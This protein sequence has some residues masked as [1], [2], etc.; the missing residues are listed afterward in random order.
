MAL[1]ACSTGTDAT[2]AGDGTGTSNLSIGY[3]PVV[4]S[5]PVVQ[6]DNGG[7]FGDEGLDVELGQTTGGAQAIPALMAGEYDIVFSNYVS[8]ILA[9]QQGLP[10]QVIAANNVG[11]AD[12]GIVVPADS[13]VQSV[14][15]LEG[16]KVAVS[17]LK[18]IGVL[19]I[20]AIMMDAGADPN[21]VQFVELPYPDMQGALER[22]DIDAMWLVEPFMANAIDSGHR[23]LTSLFTGTMENAPVSGW[24][25]TAEF[26]QQNP[27][28]IAAF[29][30]A[31][32]TA[33]DE[34]NDDRAAVTALVPTY[35]NM[36]EEQVS[37]I[38][39]PV[40]GAEIDQ[41][42]IASIADIMLKIGFI[43]DPFD[44]SSSFIY[45]GGQS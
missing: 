32:T 34:L 28:T 19:G 30:R 25:T 2:P 10:I 44:V 11:A 6:A 12:H 27:D 4:D 37:D 16:T 13:S 3:F 33:A 20:S 23:L 17:H 45:A 14:A 42:G 15:D 36:T 43:T 18:N 21:E 7:A 31:I 39:L 40:W 5:A 26:A 29:Q 9:A 38:E 24:F 35:T 41:A 8:G 1:T 22:G